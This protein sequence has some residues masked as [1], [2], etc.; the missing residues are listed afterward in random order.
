VIVPGTTA[1]HTL[2]INDNDATTVSIAATDATASET[3]GNNGQFTVTLD[4]G[5]IAP[6]AGIVVNYAIA[7][8]AANTTDY[9]TLAG[10]VMIHRRE[11]PPRRR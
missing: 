1:I 8:T 2:T 7:G 3:A 4:G 6:A 5:K 11:R 9:N 10:T